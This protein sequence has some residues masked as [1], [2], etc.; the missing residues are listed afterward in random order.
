MYLMEALLFTLGG[1]GLL[2]VVLRMSFMFFKSLEFR[3]ILDIVDGIG[4]ASPA[5]IAG[6][7]PTSAARA[8]REGDI[9]SR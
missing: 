8:N 4:R 3:V 1:G 9:S 6:E 2:L 7:T 5:E